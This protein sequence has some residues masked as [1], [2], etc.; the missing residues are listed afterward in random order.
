[1]IRAVRDVDKSMDDES[2]LSNVNSGSL[3]YCANSFSKL[4]G[5]TNP[6]KCTDSIQSGPALLTRVSSQY[7]HSRFHHNII[8]A[9]Q[10][11]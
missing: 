5:L 10:N 4:V 1:M 2:L 7:C 11:S 8:G 3:K 9:S 6:L